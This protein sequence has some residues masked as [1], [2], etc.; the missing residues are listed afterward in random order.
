MTYK[1]LR[2][3]LF[4]VERQDMTVKELRRIL[5]EE[6]EDSDEVYADDL[7][8]MTTD[9]YETIYYQKLMP[10][11]AYS[12]IRWYTPTSEDDYNRVMNLLK[13]DVEY[14]KVDR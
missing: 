7:I 4:Y 12:E 1:E 11:G 6:A 10:N 2:R 14:H 9:K 5:F 8:R 13:D 3:I